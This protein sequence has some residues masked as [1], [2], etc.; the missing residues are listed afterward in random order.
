MSGNPFETFKIYNVA[1]VSSD[2]NVSQQ[3]TG[4]RR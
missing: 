4:L 1:D 2:S 3:I